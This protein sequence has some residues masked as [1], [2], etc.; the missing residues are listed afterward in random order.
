MA[1]AAASFSVPCR[2]VLGAVLAGFLCCAVKGFVMRVVDCGSVSLSG[3]EV[4]LSRSGSQV[5][6]RKGGIN[7]WVVPQHGVDVRH[8]Y[9]C[10]LPSNDLQNILCLVAELEEQYYAPNKGHA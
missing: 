4:L 9:T 1:G 2:L 10:W 6:A 3:L 5:Y 7:V 8:Q